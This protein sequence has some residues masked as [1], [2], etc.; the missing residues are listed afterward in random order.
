[1]VAPDIIRA[2]TLP[3]GRTYYALYEEGGQVY[4]CFDQTILERATKR[5]EIPEPGE[6]AKDGYVTPWEKYNPS[7]DG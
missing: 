1:M 7:S 4:L 3:D 6:T 2:D 5:L